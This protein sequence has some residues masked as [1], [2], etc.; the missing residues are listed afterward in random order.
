MADDKPADEFTVQFPA[1]LLIHKHSP[2]GAPMFPYF[3]GSGG[4]LAITLFTDEAAVNEF[5]GASPGLPPV[6]AVRFKDG[7][8]LAAALSAVAVPDAIV[9]A[10]PRAS[11]GDCRHVWPVAHVVERLAAG[12]PL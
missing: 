11:V 4:R 5:V 10:D 7:G 6:K 3:P 8:L 9:V 1:Y 12:K 2:P